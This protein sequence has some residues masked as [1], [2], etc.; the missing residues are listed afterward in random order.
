MFFHVHHS[1]FTT[2]AHVLIRAQKRVWEMILCHQ[3][4]SKDSDLDCSFSYLLWVSHHH[5]YVGL[6]VGP[7]T[8]VL[9]EVEP[10]WPFLFHFSVFGQQSG[11]SNGE[12]S[13]CCI[14]T[15]LVLLAWLSFKVTIRKGEKKW[16]TG[17]HLL[18][19]FPCPYHPPCC[20]V[21][22]KIPQFHPQTH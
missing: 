12:M 5:F 21:G 17:S 6:R 15:E 1:P 16:P 19:Y 2:K 8:G 20:F 3:E 10:H 4:H 9:Q 14:S 22:R 13:P 7:N 18:I 11:S